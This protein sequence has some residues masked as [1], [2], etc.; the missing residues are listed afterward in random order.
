MT[1][2]MAHIGVQIDGHTAPFLSCDS[3]YRSMIGVP[4]ESS[5]IRLVHIPWVKP[6]PGDAVG[7]RQCRAS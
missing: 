2:V 3:C 7:G 6:V 5:D 4:V 1:Y